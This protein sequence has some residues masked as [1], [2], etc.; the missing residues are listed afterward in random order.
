MANIIVW[1]LE[2]EKNVDDMDGA[3]TEDR[4]AQVRAGEAGISC[5]VLYDSDTQRYHL[6]DKHNLDEGVD[7][8]N[9]ADLLVGYNTIAFDSEVVHG[10]TGRWVTA[11][12]YDILHEIWRS[13]GTHRKGFK[14]DEVAKRTI[15]L[16]KSAHGEGAPTLV[17]KGH[18][19]TL[20]DYCLND[21][22]LTKTLFNHIV[23]EESVLDKNDEPLFLARP[24]FEERI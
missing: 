21:V 15:G 6:Y 24:W 11:A 8:L 2:I 22:H 18:W 14:L 23:A 7:H 3:S 5:M 10:V 12:Q 9:G 19:A 13:L 17:K 20:F 16:T 1:D 4:W